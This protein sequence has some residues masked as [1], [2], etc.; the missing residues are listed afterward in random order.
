M[1]IK[2]RIHGEL[3]KFERY[4]K[5]LV[6]SNDESRLEIGRF[7]ILRNMTQTRIHGIKNQVIWW[8]IR[9]EIEDW[10]WEKNSFRKTIEN[11][12]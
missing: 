11:R 6:K 7:D 5:N 1:V 3:G 10:R 12:N 2:G 9:R 8:R 4:L